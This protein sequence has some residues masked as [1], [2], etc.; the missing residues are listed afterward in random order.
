[1]DITS[2]AQAADGALP[3]ARPAAIVTH[4]ADDGKEVEKITKA[5]Q[6]GHD[7]KKSTAMQDLTSPPPAYRIKQRE[8]FYQLWRMKHVPEPPASLDD[9]P[10]IPLADANFLQELLYTWISPL[11]RL[12]AARPL[13]AGRSSRSVGI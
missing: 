7:Q 5:K 13:Q 9:A 8:R 12:G 6:D 1:M 2:N 4:A 11:M 3:E 10:I